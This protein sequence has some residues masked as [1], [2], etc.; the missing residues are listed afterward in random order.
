MTSISDAS[1]LSTYLTSTSDV[2]QNPQRVTVV[3]DNFVTLFYG[4]VLRRSFILSP[5]STIS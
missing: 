2:S 4:L 3:T 5:Q 1:T